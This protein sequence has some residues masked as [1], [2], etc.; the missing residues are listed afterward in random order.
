MEQNG[1]ELSASVNGKAAKVVRLL[2]PDDPM[3]LLLVLDLVGDLSQVA[4]AQQAMVETV[5]RLPPHVFVGV[6]RAQDGLR[7]LLDPSPDREDAASAIQTLAVS[8]RAGLLDTVELAVQLGDSML[9]AAQVRMAVLYVTDSDVRNYREDFSNPVVNRS[10]SRDLSRRFPQ[11]L[12]REKIAKLNNSL[13]RSE[14]PVFMVHLDYRSD[15]LNEAYQ[16]GLLE[17]AGTTGGRAEFCRT[18]ADIPKTVASVFSYAIN[19]SSAVVDIPEGTPRQ[20]L[21]SFGGISSTQ[22][23]SRFQ[24]RDK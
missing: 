6:L 23:R 11:G 14:T 10:D 2:G 5:R 17:L 1:G 18:V 3:V 16:T 24:L 15:T 9:N 4:P 7:V 20:A 12:I 13:V 8:G 22:H 19:T 21:V